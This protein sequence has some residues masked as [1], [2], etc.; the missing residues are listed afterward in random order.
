MSW[1]NPKVN[2]T[3]N[4]YCNAED[5][6]RIES[7]TVEVVNRIDAL[8][9]AIPQLTTI[10]DRDNTHIDFISSINRIET[11]ID[12]IKDNFFTPSGYQDSKTWSVGI[13]FTFQDANRLES[14]LNLLYILAQA[15]Q[16]NII[17][18]GT[19]SSGSEWEGGLYG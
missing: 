1:I 15:V 14:N 6:N 3:S 5:L 12:T 18:C 19:F 13:G 11:N 16:N 2:W 9:Y 10:T 7:N 17:Y 8:G 4:D